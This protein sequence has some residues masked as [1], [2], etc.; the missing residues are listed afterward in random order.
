M[1]LM[2]FLV[3]I[4]SLGLT[5]VYDYMMFRWNERKELNDSWK[6]LNDSL[7]REGKQRWDQRKS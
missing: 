3:A 6:A 1:D 2:Y 4:L 7:E 5:V